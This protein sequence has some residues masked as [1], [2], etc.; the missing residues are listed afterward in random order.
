MNTSVVLALDNRRTKSDGTCSVILRLV[1][2]GASAQI[3]TGVSVPEKDW[4]AKTRLVKGTYKGTE[5]VARINNLLRKKRGEALDII[6]KLEEQ[7]KLKSL[8]IHQIKELLENKTDSLSFIAFAEEI[9]QELND[10]NRIG[11]ARAHK[12]GLSALKKF[13]GGDI[14][15]PQLNYLF[16]IKFEQNHMKNGN[17]Y[18]GLSVYLR[19]IRAIYNSAIKRGLVD[20]SLYPFTN[21]EIKS[22]KTRKRAI[23]FDAI[24][25]IFDLQLQPGHPLYHSRNLFLSSFYMRGMSFTDLAQLQLLNIIDGRIHYDRQKTGK[26]YNI[27]I[28]DE[29]MKI[30]TPY[31]QGK[32]Q[33]DYIFPIL[34]RDT[35][36]EQYKDMDNMRRRYN[37]KLK[38]IAK[39]CGIEANLTSY[40]SRHSFATRAKN[41]GIPIANISDML[42]HENI[43]TTAVYL[44]SLP[45]DELDNFHEMVIKQ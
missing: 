31:L 24:K 7:K 10:A 20:R 18:N 1:H 27:K 2:F 11:T 40:V 4:D 38:K 8:T 45:S 32:G 33:E 9:I 17:T 42:G 13:A 12:S 3:A 37:K 39:L 21:Y 34:K 19:S 44:D 16:L 41:L 6:F 25:K 36:A 26:P 29:L 43:K 28:P 5:S 15:F 35:E 22:T 30:L 23:G 14:T